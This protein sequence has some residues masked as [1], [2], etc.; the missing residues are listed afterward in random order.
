MKVKCAERGEEEAPGRPILV[1]HHCGKPVCADH[2]L[3][4]TRDEAFA[5]TAVAPVSAVH[6]PE[7]KGKYHRGAATQR[8]TANDGRPVPPVWAG[9][10]AAS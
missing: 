10:K 9:A 2:A 6:C 5:G 8:P 4:V 1:C 3:E 7:C